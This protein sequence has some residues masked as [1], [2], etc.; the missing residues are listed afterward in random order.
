MGLVCLFAIVS[1][2]RILKIW[3][4]FLVKTSGE[5]HKKWVNFYPPKLSTLV[6]GVPSSPVLSLCHIIGYLPARGTFRVN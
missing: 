1:I 6:Q 2:K 5:Q 4:S 3:N